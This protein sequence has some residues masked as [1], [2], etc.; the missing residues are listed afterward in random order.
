[1]ENRTFD[2]YEVVIKTANRGYNITHNRHIL[3]L[4]GPFWHPG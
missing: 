3:T 2:V 4:V 1:L